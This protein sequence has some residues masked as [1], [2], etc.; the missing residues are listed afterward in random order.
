MR[1]VKEGRNIRGSNKLLRA[2]DQSQDSPDKT[3]VKTMVG[4]RKVK[5]RRMKGGGG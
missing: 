3:L 1:N 2:A 4:E 5:T